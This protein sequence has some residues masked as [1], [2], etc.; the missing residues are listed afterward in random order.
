MLTETQR[1]LLVKNLKEKIT[2]V[3]VNG[4]EIEIKIH[5]ADEGFDES[6]P[7]GIIRFMPS[8]RKKNQSVSDFIG[9][10]ENGQFSEFGYDQV[11]LLEL[12]CY[13][14]THHKDRVVHG[15]LI[16]DEM[17]RKILRH[18]YKNWNMGDNIL[19]KM[20]AMIDNVDTVP[21]IREMTLYAENKARKI[22]IYGG[23]VYLLTM[24]RWTDIPEDWDGSSIDIY[25]I[26]NVGIDE[27]GEEYVANGSIIL[28]N[29]LD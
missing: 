29:I 28:N 19:T 8:S 13:A 7:F 27:S 15:R 2:S 25:S 17:Y 9:T 4:V 10:L 23:D 3:T 18:I 12:R 21:Y 26:G 5:R 20:G 16:V 1:G 24:F 11:E 6:H 22:Y 14:Q